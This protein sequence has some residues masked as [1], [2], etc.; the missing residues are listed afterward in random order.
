MATDSTYDLFIQAMNVTN[1]AMEANSESIA[2][3][4][5]LTACSQE[6]ANEDFGV[7][8][9]DNDPANPVDHFTIRLK[10]VSFVLVSHDSPADT[11]PTWKVS[12]MYLRDVISNPR[13]YIDHPSLLAF[14]WLRRRLGQTA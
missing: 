7:A 5:M 8:I 1:A 10:G 14:D 9:Y 6:L 13:K 11:D 3:K 4:P 12:K 2:L